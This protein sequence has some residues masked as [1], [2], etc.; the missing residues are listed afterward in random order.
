MFVLF[1]F[2]IE[3]ADLL[4]RTDN[5]PQYLQLILILIFLMLLSL[6]FFSTYYQSLAFNCIY[7]GLNV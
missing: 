1:V 5:F 7:S 4:V 2:L 3:T 6:T